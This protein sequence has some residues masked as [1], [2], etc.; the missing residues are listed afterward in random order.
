[1]IKDSPRVIDIQWIS[2]EFLEHTVTD[3]EPPTMHWNSDSLEVC[4]TDD[5]FFK[6]VREY[7]FLFGTLTI[8]TSIP[9]GQE[10]RYIKLM[11][12]SLGKW[13]KIIVNVSINPKSVTRLKKAWILK[14]ENPVSFKENLVPSHFKLNES[15]NLSTVWVNRDVLIDNWS[16]K[17]APIETD[18]NVC[19]FVYWV[20]NVLSLSNNV[21]SQFPQWK[22]IVPINK[23]WESVPSLKKWD[24]VASLLQECVITRQWLSDFD[25]PNK[26]YK[27]SLFLKN[28]AW[29]YKV[30]V[31]S[32]WK[33]LNFKVL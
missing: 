20:Y 2:P 21:S 26:Y 31:D 29:K 3:M 13:E 9:K 25:I 5:D 18:V 15:D 6:L 4:E 28:H 33:V 8:A 23:I 12:S 10:G 7:I 24:L 22:L 16:S 14:N 1:M 27:Y 32:Y 30:I 17:D 11:Q 19:Q